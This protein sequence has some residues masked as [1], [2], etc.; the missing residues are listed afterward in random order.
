MPQEL[1]AD[2]VDLPILV[3]V[4]ASLLDVDCVYPIGHGPSY[5][6]VSFAL[7]FFFSNLLYAFSRHLFLYSHLE[8]A[9]VLLALQQVVLPLVQ[10][11]LVWEQRV[12]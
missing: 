3:A 4:F 5:H 8:A 9:L 11:E 7:L 10:R 2:V 6:D 12:Q 1:L